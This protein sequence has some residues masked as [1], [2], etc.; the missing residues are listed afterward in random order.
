MHVN[1]LREYNYREASNSPS[2]YRLFVL[3]FNR[4][5]YLNLTRI[6]STKVAQARKLLQDRDL[7]DE[8]EKIDS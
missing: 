3:P 7:D 4:T 8:R 6:G 1:D 5:E 2:S